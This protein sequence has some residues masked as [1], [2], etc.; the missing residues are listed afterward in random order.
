MQP[1]IGLDPITGTL[2]TNVASNLLQNI[3]GPSQPSGPSSADIA[4]ALARQRQQQ[5]ADSA[6]RNAWMIG[7][8]LAAVGVVAVW[9]LSS[10][11]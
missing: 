5:Q 8:G 4:A 11:R 3:F 1:T 10:R 9:M 6:R 2:L 7:I